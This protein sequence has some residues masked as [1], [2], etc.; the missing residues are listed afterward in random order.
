MRGFN[1]RQ[2]RFF[3]FIANARST[4]K[5]WFVGVFILRELL[6]LSKQILSPI[7]A[8]QSLIFIFPFLKM[9]IKIPLTPKNGWYL[10]NSLHSLVIFNL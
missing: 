7:F 9:G 6:Y 5:H 8:V 2:V 1:S 3:I 10:Y 4:D